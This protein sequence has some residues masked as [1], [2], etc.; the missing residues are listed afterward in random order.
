MVL[1]RH[2]ELLACLLGGITHAHTLPPPT[3][4]YNAGLRPYILKHTTHND[5][6]APNGTGT[7]VLVNLYYPTL[8]SAYPVRYLYQGLST[9][10][11]NYW[12]LPSSILYNVTAV[13]NPGAEPLPPSV[14]ASLPTLI[15]GPPF[16]GPDSI[17]FT[18][19]LSDL[20]SYGYTIITIDHPYEQPF[21]EYPDGTGIPGLPVDVNA[22]NELVEAVLAYRYTDTSALLD[23]LPS[24]AKDWN[25]FPINLTH[26]VFFGHSV[27]GSA[28]LSSAIIEQN[29]TINGANINVLGAINLDGSNWDRV[30]ANDSS[31][32]LA[33]PSLLL[34]SE[35][36]SST[37]DTTWS[38]FESQ[39]TAWCKELQVAGTN[40]T[41]FSDII[42]W[43]QW[44]GISE[45]GEG[46]IESHRM[47]NLTRVFVRAFMDKVGRGTE[48][49][50]L[51]MDEWVKK[52]WPEVGTVFENEAT[53]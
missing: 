16:A 23:V 19:L 36:H 43:K 11:E 47:A 33:V 53:S 38:N 51:S 42:L 8:H 44:F 13:I 26:F 50:V 3:G 37:W 22:T 21:L 1:Q 27:G 17:A 24:I 32:N 9:Y 31:A 39:Q 25:D 20:A 45:P 30:S 5:P 34:G 40:H 48:G 6:V 46:I 29:R 2:F 4:P 14:R 35:L 49:G 28:A 52:E 41:D 10:Y 18:S 12:K 7:S 15:F